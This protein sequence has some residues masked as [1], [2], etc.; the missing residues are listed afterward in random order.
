MLL[1][2]GMSYL[3]KHAFIAEFRGYELRNQ[4]IGREGDLVFDVPLKIRG[5]QEDRQTK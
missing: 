4:A 1:L 5:K 2:G 3:T